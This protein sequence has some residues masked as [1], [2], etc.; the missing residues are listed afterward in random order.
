MKGISGLAAVFL[1]AALLTGCSVEDTSADR[2]RQSG[3]V[4]IALEEG[5]ELNGLS[6]YIADSLGVGSEVITVDK[7]KALSLVKSGGAD[8]ALGFYPESDNPGLEYCLSVPFHREYMY[9]VCPADITITAS[10]DLSDK[11][12]GCDVTMEKRSIREAT[13]LSS[14]GR[15]YCEDAQ[16]AVEMFGEESLYA[17]LCYEDEAFDMVS[18]DSTLRCYVLADIRP[19]NYCAVVMRE[20]TQLC[21][22]INT[23]IGT[24]LAGGN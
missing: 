19:Q 13:M 20:N 17:F 7:Y 9:A 1:T 5:A 18:S 10:E 23:A 22:E 12:L 6:E 16:A 11:L 3:K 8:I 4:R 15:I 14:K 21:G 24:F 2:V